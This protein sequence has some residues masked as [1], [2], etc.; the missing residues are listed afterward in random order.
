MPIL[1]RI[2]ENMPAPTSRQGQKQRGKRGR[3]G[4]HPSALVLCPT[5]ELA[6]QIHESFST[7]GKKLHLDC[8]TIFGGVSQ[9]WQVRALNHGVDIVVATPGRLL[10]L[11]NQGLVNLKSVEFLVLD[12]AD[13]MLDMG[14]IDDIRKIIKRLPIKRQTLL[15][16][17]T[18]PSEIRKLSDSILHEPEFIK[19]DPVASPAE[20]IQQSVY[21][22]PKNRKPTLITR[23]LERDSQGRTLIFTRTKHGADRLVKILRKADIEAAAIHGNKTQNAR[24]R[25]LGAFKTG[26]VPILIATDIASRGIDVD[27]ITHVFNYDLPNVAET[28]VHRIGRTARAGA[29][30]TAI[31]FCDEEQIK[32][33]RAIEKLMEMDIEVVVDDPEFSFEPST[34]KDG[35]K[36]RSKSKRSGG[37][38]RSPSRTAGK[39]KP[40]TRGRDKEDS[41][42]SRGGGKRKPKTRTR[43]RDSEDA[44]RPRGKGKPKS[45]PK[46]KAKP[47]AKP[48]AK[49][50]AK[51]KSKTKPKSKSRTK[52]RAGTGPSKGSGKGSGKKAHRKGLGKGLGKGGGKAAAKKKAP[53]KRATGS[54]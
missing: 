15:F 1:H 33:L 42:R 51:P 32:D 29:S 30:G 34:G 28:Y 49:A 22:V 25:A 20:L 19:V 54:S 18:M 45:K 8:T 39:K 16:S 47:K 27:E 41:D 13:R 10:D 44:D 26:R 46:A 17:A 4:R 37:G 23:L 3:T 14:F 40:R 38:K 24:T 11:M 48:K 52:S 43:G 35:K 7:Y 31:S 50:K 2:A 9:H 12:E 6:S 53:G 21:M 36:S 5:R